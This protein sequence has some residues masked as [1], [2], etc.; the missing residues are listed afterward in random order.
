MFHYLQNTR[1]DHLKWT[2]YQVVLL[3]LSENNDHYNMYPF[4]TFQQ[5]HLYFQIVHR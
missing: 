2:Q 3:E 4:H 1:V 5:L